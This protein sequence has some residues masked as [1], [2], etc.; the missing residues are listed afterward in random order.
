M[1][2]SGAGLT[3]ELTAEP[4]QREVLPGNRSLELG[5]GKENYYVVP[6][7]LGILVFAE[8]NGPSRTRYRAYETGSGYSMAM[9]GA[10][11]EGSALLVTWKDPYTEIFT[12]YRPSP[13]R[14][15]VSLALRR[16]ARGVRFQT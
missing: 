14:L 13:A 6:K 1:R 3:Y 7:R 2:I 9:F 12:D 4:G 8:G 16:T 11:K 5:P 15:A 10:V